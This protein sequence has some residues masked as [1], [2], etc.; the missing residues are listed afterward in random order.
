MRKLSNAVRGDREFGW[1]QEYLQGANQ[2][3][4]PTTLSPAFAGL[5]FTAAASLVFR[6]FG[7]VLLGVGIPNRNYAA[8]QRK[9][10]KFERLK[11]RLGGIH[12]AEEEQFYETIQVR[13]SD[14]DLFLNPGAYVIRG[15]EIAFIITSQSA[16]AKIISEF[17]PRDV[18]DA[19]VSADREKGVFAAVKRRFMGGN[20]S[21][22]SNN[23]QPTSTT[24]TLNQDG[25]P[26]VDVSL[27]GSVRQTPSPVP[28][29]TS[30]SGSALRL[31]GGSA[32]AKRVAMQELVRA[33]HHQSIAESEVFPGDAGGKL[34]LAGKSTPV[35]R[36]TMFGGSSVD[37]SDA[38]SALSFSGGRGKQA[39]DNADATGFV[40]KILQQAI[41]MNAGADTAFRRQ[42]ANTMSTDL[43][44]AASALSADDDRYP[45]QLPDH[46]AKHILVCDYSPSFPVGLEY[47]IAPLRSAHLQTSGVQA[48]IAW[49]PI[50]ILSPEAP[51]EQ[52]RRVLAKFDD[53]YVLQGTP[54]SR[55]DLRRAGVQRCRKA[56]VLA[57]TEKEKDHQQ[58]TAD[59]SSLLVVLNIESL[60]QQEDVFIATEFIHAENMKVW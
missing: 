26:P 56:V 12:P 4:Y 17:S 35:K 6:T 54:L 22:G 47:F 8:K 10:Q 18:H 32:T 31:G 3:I 28:P 46:V 37:N 44:E 34:L 45:S 9:R 20:G 41:G 25:S 15:G 33:Q 48:E 53:I 27:S 7:A 30:G 42:R 57:N 29:S 19:V 14:Y 38:A 39:A 55:K 2:E 60:T 1:A 5:K 11:Q 24:P 50:V 58:R 40:S 43:S 16:F 36:M 13:P 21:N 51:S 49:P 52:Q 59:A 23:R